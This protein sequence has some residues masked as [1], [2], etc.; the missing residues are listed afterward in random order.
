MEKSGVLRMHVFR[1]SLVRKCLLTIAKYYRIPLKFQEDACH[2]RSSHLLY[3]WS[4]T[5]FLNYPCICSK[6]ISLVF[7]T[8]NDKGKQCKYNDEW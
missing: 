3:C 5:L 8:L 1:S 6:T 7:L 2:G 4:R